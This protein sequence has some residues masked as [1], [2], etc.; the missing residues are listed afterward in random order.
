MPHGDLVLLG[1]IL[2]GFGLA[3]A[4]GFERQLRGSPA[5]DRT[6]ALVGAASTAI[7][8]VAG[9][10]SPQ[11]VAGVVTGI[12]FIGAGVVFHGAGGLVRGL[13]SAAAIFGVAGIGIVVGF[14]HLFLGVITA[15]VLLFALE[16]PHAPFLRWLDARTYSHRFQ[17]DHAPDSGSES[18]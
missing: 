18:D 8:A 17:D 10:T 11:T 4:F 3:Y 12:G 13:T 15:A 1:R 2:L 6:F 16:L 7:T 14:G 9:P 5:G